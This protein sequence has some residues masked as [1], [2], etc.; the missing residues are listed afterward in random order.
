MPFPAWEPPGSHY[1]SCSS[2]HTIL[3]ALTG[4]PSKKVF[5]FHLHCLLTT[6]KK[7]RNTYHEQLSLT[8]KNCQN[9]PL[10]TSES[11]SVWSGRCSPG[12]ELA[13]RR[14]S[15]FR[16][17]AKAKKDPRPTIFC[18]QKNSQNSGWFGERKQKTE[19]ARR[20]TSSS[21]NAMQTQSHVKYF[22]ICY[23]YSC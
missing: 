2:P 10:G 15:W 19:V 7:K 1:P 9:L 12:T 6:G 18:P 14:N 13:R 22:L 3:L 16:G 8:G 20:L 4:Y 23:W 17:S 5:H 11:G 21:V